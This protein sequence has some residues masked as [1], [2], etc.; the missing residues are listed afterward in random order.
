MILLLKGQPSRYFPIASQHPSV[1]NNTGFFPINQVVLATNC[2]SG[3][4]FLP[5]RL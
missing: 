2:I 3:S 4:L 5:L 1:W